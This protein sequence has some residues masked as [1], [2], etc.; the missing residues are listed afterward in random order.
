MKNKKAIAIFITSLAILSLAC[1]V[2]GYLEYKKGDN[3]PTE[4][5]ITYKYYLN[6]S[7]VSEMPTNA[8]LISSSTESSSSEEPEKLYA[9]NSAT[10]TNK[11]KYTWDEDTWTFKTDNSADS[12]CKLYFVTTFNQITITAT[13]ATITPLSNN[14]IKRGEDAIITITPTEGYK[15]KQAICTNNEVTEWDKEKKL[16]T[17]KNIYA[18]TSCDVTYEMSKFSVEVKVNNGSGDTTLEYNYGTKV[19]VSIQA[20]SGYGIPDVTCTNDQK[21]TWT[22][23]TFTISKLTDDTICTVNFKQIQNITYTVEMDVGE[24][25]ILSSG[26]SIVTVKSGASASF[27][28]LVTNNN[29]V[30]HSATCTEGGTARRVSNIITIENVTKDI[31]CD[32]VYEPQ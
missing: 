17:V 31:K 9:F 8:T 4:R 18:D 19:E 6:N 32:V 27:T 2:V 3:A 26:T 1:G 14:K 23:G 5:V 22:N 7:E 21:A 11:V 29:Y 24:H 13:N 16:L 10:C 25:G 30:L 28:I 15:Y 12:T 20:S